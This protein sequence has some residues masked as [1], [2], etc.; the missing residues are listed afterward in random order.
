AGGP[1]VAAGWSTAAPSRRR[2]R[3][4]DYRNPRFSQRYDNNQRRAASSAASEVRWRYQSKCRAIETVLAGTR[5]TAQGRA[6]YLADH[7]RRYGLRRLQHFWWS[8]PDAESRPH[9]RQRP[10]L[11]QLQ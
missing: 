1:H 6:E 2:F 7:D 10:A 3:A 4:A 11:H 9:R 8:D 5:R